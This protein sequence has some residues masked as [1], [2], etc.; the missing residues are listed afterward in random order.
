MPKKNTVQKKHAKFTLTE[1][2]TNTNKPK[3]VLQNLLKRWENF[4]IRTL[5]TLKPNGLNHKLN[6]EWMYPAVAQFK[7]KFVVSFE[8]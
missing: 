2:L 4:L 6:S 7:F 5:E 3:E 8:M 1:C